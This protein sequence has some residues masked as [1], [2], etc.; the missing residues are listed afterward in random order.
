M[1][2]FDMYR[3]GSSPIRRLKYFGLALVLVG[4]G[5]A[6]QE[7]TF[8]VLNPT[9]NPPPVELKAMA[10]RPAS[11][12]GKT[13]FFVDQTFNNAD[14]LLEEMMKWFNM[15]MPEVKTEYRRKTGGY[16]T[17]DPALW[18]EIQAAEG[19]MIMAIGH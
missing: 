5:A 9:G 4:A 15:H 16:T 10:P 8:M 7:P 18:R 3:A 2:F 11:L 13:I 19:L 6:A 17:D 1:A 12:D 14:V